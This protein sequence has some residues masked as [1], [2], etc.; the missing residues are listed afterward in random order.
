[1]WQATGGPYGQGEF[2]SRYLTAGTLFTRGSSSLVC[3]VTTT[4]TRS[5]PEGQ[6]GQGEY[7]SRYIA[8]GTLFLRGDSSLR[9][10]HAGT[11]RIILSAAAGLRP[12]VGEAGGV[13]TTLPA[14]PRVSC[15][16]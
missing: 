10:V 7:G 15:R 8:P 13:G 9:C 6:Y 3:S 11:H 16:S 14:G 5:L 4:S 1:M 12:V 2:G